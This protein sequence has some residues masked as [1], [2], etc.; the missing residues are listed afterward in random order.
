MSKE[1]FV[2]G[3]LIL[4]NV[5]EWITFDA[6]DEFEP[7]IW[8][9]DG[10]T[11]EPVN[12]YNDIG[13]V[14]NTRY[15]NNYNPVELFSGTTCGW[16]SHMFMTMSQFMNEYRRI[17]FM[18]KNDTM[19]VKKLQMDRSDKLLHTAKDGKRIQIAN[20]I[21]NRAKMFING[22]DS[23][24]IIIPIEVN[25]AAVQPTFEYLQQIANLEPFDFPTPSEQQ[26][27]HMEEKKAKTGDDDIS[28]DEADAYLDLNAQ[29]IDEDRM[30]EEIQ[31]A[32]DS[33]DSFME[34]EE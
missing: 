12:E 5:D 20:T 8:I 23:G 3:D 30:V 2:K 10:V 13:R 32:M 33:Y 18:M 14:T 29:K 15:V 11:S 34:D 1:K 21:I 24:D 16:G 26:M 4:R 6:G 25:D 7:C 31:E 22:V 9:C 17:N 28:V 19:Y 27:K